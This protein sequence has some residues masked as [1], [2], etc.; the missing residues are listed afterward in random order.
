[1]GT[2]LVVAFVLML[3]LK[4]AGIIVWSWWIVCLPLY[5]EMVRFI[6]VLCVGGG[7]K[8]VFS[9]GQIFKEFSRRKKR[10]KAIMNDEDYFEL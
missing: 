8:S 2:A 4:L 5:I 9:F 6:V 7:I 3:I 1:M 10:M